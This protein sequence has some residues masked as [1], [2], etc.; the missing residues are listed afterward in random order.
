[1]SFKTLLVI[2]IIVP[3][4]IVIRLLWQDYELRMIEYN[5]HVCAV[6]G[7]MPD[8]KTPLPTKEQIDC[9]NHFNVP[10]NRDGEV[11]NRIDLVPVKIN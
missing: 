11:K 8:C 3:A 9:Q 6:Y 4:V 1:M 10:C 7:K 5:A 2:V